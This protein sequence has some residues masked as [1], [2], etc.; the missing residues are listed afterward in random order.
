MKKNRVCSCHPIESI[1]TL[2]PRL[3]IFLV[4]ST[5]SNCSV[6]L[7]FP[8]CIQEHDKEAPNKFTWQGFFGGRG[9]R[10]FH[11]TQRSSHWWSSFLASRTSRLSFRKLLWTF[12]QLVRVL[13]NPW[14]SFVCLLKLLSAKPRQ[15]R[16]WWIILV[17]VAWKYSSQCK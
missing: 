10:R 13:I 1:D 8:N 5:S 6:T 14:D 4:S 3:F 7:R 11:E 2:S 9:E 15:S 17:R 16:I 12:K